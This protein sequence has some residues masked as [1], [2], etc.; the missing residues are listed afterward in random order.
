MSYAEEYAKRLQQIQAANLYGQ[1]TSQP[2]SKA[3]FANLILQKARSDWSTK[4]TPP[5]KVPEHKGIGGKF[6]SV[7]LG[8]LDILSRPDYAFNQA[9]D[10]AF[11]GSTEDGQTNIG[12]AA[13]EGLSGK[14]QTSFIDVLQHQHKNDI[15]KS[16]DYKNILKTQGNDAADEYR[17][18]K[19]Q[20]IDQ[21]KFEDVGGGLLVDLVLDPL[22]AV[23][24]G[25]LSKPIKAIKG[26]KDV[27]KLTAESNVAEHVAEGIGRETADVPQSAPAEPTTSLPAKPG[28]S[29]E[30]IDKLRMARTPNQ[31]TVTPTSFKGH[32]FITSPN[33]PKLKKT[34]TIDSTIQGL[35]DPVLQKHAGQ[36][37]N[38]TDLRADLETSLRSYKDPKD[39][40]KN[41]SLWHQD[42]IEGIKDTV[43]NS[44]KGSNPTAVPSST[45][46]PRV[47]GKF[48]SNRRPPSKTIEGQK[49]EADYSGDL[50]GKL[51]EQPRFA[52]LS[53]VFNKDL[54]ESDFAD[55]QKARLQ[56][57]T[58]QVVDQVA[59]GNPSAADLITSKAITPLTPVA[60]AAVLRHVGQTIREIGESIADPAKARAAGKQPRHP[61]NNAPTQSNLSNRLTNEARQ[62]L[63]REST[64]GRTGSKIN[65]AAAPALIPAVYDRYIEMLSNAEEALVH[66]G[67]LEKNDAL[68]PRGG[69]KP[70]SPY[71]RLSDVLKAIPK[72]LA[73]T[74]ILGTKGKVLPSILLKA[75]TGNNAAL[76]KISKINRP[77]FDA[78]QST[79]WTPLMVKEYATRTIDG[80]NAA[81]QTTDD[82]A[83]FIA[84]KFADNTASDVNKA[85]VMDETVK[86][87]KR[88]FVKE[89]PEV[90]AT[91]GEMLDG[92]RKSIP[93]PVPDPIDDIIERGKNKL[94][95]GVFSAENGQKVAQ[96]PRI[97]TATAV[98]EDAIEAPVKAAGVDPTLA[99][100]A[101]EKGIFST[102]LKWF[103]PAAG[104]KE[105]R[106]LVLKNISARKTS[107]TTR[108]HEII[109]LFGTIPEIEHM[110]FWKE[111]TGVMP[112]TPDHAPAVATMQKMFENLFGD[113]GL[114]KKFAGNTAISRAG[115]NVDH[116]NKHMNIVGIKDFKFTRDIPD[117]MNPSKTI[118]LN[119]DQVLDTWKNYIPK[120]SKDLRKFV[121][122]MSQAAENSMV[123]YST[124]ANLG[125]LYG[126]KVAKNGY[127]QVSGMHSAINGMHFPKDLVSQIGA[128]AR[129]IDDM[130]EPVANSN[131]MRLYDNALRTWKTGVT[132]YAPS[133]HI[134]NMVGDVF[135]SYLDGLTN[136]IYYTKSGHMLQANARRYS[137]MKTGKNPL[138]DILGEGRESEIINQIIGNS[139]ARVPKGTRVIATARI[140]KK[141]FPITID[142]AY[143]MAFRHGL[144]PHSATIED[145]P[146]SETLMENLADRFHPG[147]MGPFA[148]AKGNVAKGVKAVAETREH[149]VRGAH[150]LYA[151]EN[152]KANSLEELFQ[153]AA[154]RVRKYH[155]DGL[156][157][158]TT[159][160]KV[161]RRLIPFYSWNRKAIPLILEGIV[162][163][164]TKITSYP[165]IMSAAQ[166]QQ[167][168]ESSVSDPWP[169][170][171][172]FPDWLSS[173]VIGPMLPPESGFA[174]SI[175]RSPKEVGYTLINPGM[176]STDIM[177]QF[178]NNPV[179][180]IENSLTPAIKIP[181]E[182]AFGRE[183]QT[184]AP[185]DDK[186]EY[187]D[188]NIPLLSTISRMTNGAVGTGIVEGGD[189]KGKE[190]SAQNLPA[191][192]NYLTA[193]G[194]LDTGR[195]IKGGEFDL[196]EKL[197][198]EKQNGSR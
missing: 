58:A 89:S 32:K 161:F 194:I 25:L 195:Y 177:T 129:G 151:L 21:G 159:E 141:K 137:D 114:A 186:T 69:I 130:Y 54:R 35:I 149:F 140:G 10:V 160:K 103:D 163:K 155:P 171:Q 55:L 109:K 82:V 172:L 16:D 173:N 136:P 147:K 48:G 26:A 28:I 33:H 72:E 76:G 49:I 67:R 37:L 98:T 13:W 111:V 14:K 39:S 75:V 61:V 62:Q 73:Q 99:A 181:A 190:T 52:N 38:E 18:S 184:G 123:E 34:H 108:A 43:I 142:Q 187:I 126:S 110:D 70:D 80:A 112:A 78:I 36:P 167:G 24:V 68:Y 57:E 17:A 65:K 156:D 162:M 133:H 197:A 44:L 1:I 41:G 143:Q 115:I 94:A 176:P 118:R 91:L 101:A 66:Q 86:A 179:K 105:L 106:P 125:S 193:A 169:D 87:G 113:S 47:E 97:A 131:L 104:Y 102:V 50:L 93:N 46:F 165:K 192:I 139:D 79:D 180:G 96:A 191:L 60:R 107:A 188:K 20:E 174:Q 138:T 120:D 148:P 198:K 84:A 56:N 150:Y 145:L 196:R 85:N 22:N 164:P 23:G 92:L 178:F 185:I 152:T 153:K 168:I 116:L 31:P 59:K 5:P 119:P 71:L 19:E 3:D 12:K 7:G 64:N 189:L 53:D 132:I 100:D 144:F 175:A 95:A 182:M 2:A 9:A 121:F 157:L 77:L 154:Q 11:N 146:G 15:L 158:T 117:P 128:M 135:T 81:H 88:E 170:D 127:V 27:A 134:R 6:K 4:Y 124:F 63:I 74:A 183:L 90:K 122:N 166:E 29:P 30:L 8:I 40:F 42:Y 45:A 51:R 83:K